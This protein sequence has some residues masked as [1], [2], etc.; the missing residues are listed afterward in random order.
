MEAWRG[1]CNGS[2]VQDRWFTNPPPDECDLDGVGFQ[3][4][5]ALLACAHFVVMACCVVSLPFVK[6]DTSRKQLY[7][8]IPHSTLAVI[9]LV[10]TLT[11][12]NAFVSTQP[13]KWILWGPYLA[14]FHFHILFG[15]T[16]LR[17]W[18]WA[19]IQLDR[20]LRHQWYES[21]QLR[22]SAALAGISGLVFSVATPVMV[23]NNVGSSIGWTIGGVLYA[24]AQLPAVLL[25]TKYMLLVLRFL[26]L[27]TS[28]LRTYKGHEPTALRRVHNITAL[29]RKLHF[30]L[31]Q[32]VLS[33]VLVPAIWTA[34][35]VKPIAPLVLFVMTSSLGL[36]T[37]CLFVY[38]KRPVVSL[39]WWT[40]PVPVAKPGKLDVVFKHLGEGANPVVVPLPGV[41]VSDEHAFASRRA[42]PVRFPVSAAANA[43]A[44][45][46]FVAL[47]L[48]VFQG[49]LPWQVGVLPLIGALALAWRVALFSSQ[50]TAYYAM[51]LPSVQLRALVSVAA[52]VVLCTCSPRRSMALVA[53]CVVQ[54]ASL[55]GDAL[56]LAAR[57]QRD[58]LL[59]ASAVTWTGIFALALSGLR[60]D[61][62]LALHPAGG[63]ARDLAFVVMALAISDVA[64][65]TW[66]RSG[67]MMVYVQVPLPYVL[68]SY[69]ARSN[70]L[71]VA[72]ANS[73]GVVTNAGHVFLIAHGALVS[74]G[75]RRT[76]WWFGGILIW[77]AAVVLAADED[78]GMAAVILAAHGLVLLLAATS[79]STE[80]L[81]E[82]LRK[83]VVRL[84]VVVGLALACSWSL[85]TV[86]AII[87]GVAHHCMVAG[88]LLT[89]FAETSFNGSQVN[90]QLRNVT[91]LGAM[92]FTTFPVLLGAFAARSNMENAH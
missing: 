52:T 70:R 76:L 32:S 90:W 68:E 56:V 71:S 29:R 50:P 15:V 27:K 2:L 49:A 28:E 42:W 84:A 65:R 82:A 44:A 31:M 3:T 51:A 14:M 69:T 11:F 66:L 1:S 78:E 92:L 34:L 39:R 16:I 53:A 64:R 6:D 8:C 20:Q 21:L 67:F 18:G 88:A 85:A 73:N 75:V 23:S 30:A 62:E 10:G 58:G 46:V 87:V 5:V 41:I 77:L 12:P 25:S 36:T 22:G 81:R 89:E 35:I 4:V 13:A 9:I 33:I 74:A 55:F 57:R 54:I 86:P 40:N 17:L 45:G 26:D 38:F 43:G 37:F 79:F 19:I 59:F 80:V 61:D 48:L 72:S 91:A 7:L 60:D 47:V 24:C 63:A 83:A